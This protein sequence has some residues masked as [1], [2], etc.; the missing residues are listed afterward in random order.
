MDPHSILSQFNQRHPKAGPMARSQ[1]TTPTQKRSEKR[2]KLQS[3]NS[4]PSTSDRRIATNSRIKQDEKYKMDM[5]L[6]FIN[7]ALQQKS[8]VGV[9]LPSVLVSDLCLSLKG[10]PTPFNELVSQFNIKRA[11]GGSSVPP[12][13][14]AQLRLWFSALSHVVS[15][16]G[17]KHA[18]L[19]QAIVNMPWTTLDSVTVRSYTMFLGNLLSARPEYLSL[20]LGKTAQGF[21]YRA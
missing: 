12:V 15:R 7:D 18:A 8:S 6:A 19:V 9:I 16:L 1:D 14:P 3:S 13:Q 4:S 2:P 20:V 10:N 21:T 17:P 5:Y 11:S